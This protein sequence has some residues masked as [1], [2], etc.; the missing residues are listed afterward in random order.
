MQDL[1]DKPRLGVSSCLLG[2][3]IRYDGGHCRNK[4]VC[5]QLGLFFQ[6]VPICPEVEMGMPVPRETVRLVAQD[7]RTRL[8]GN[9]SGTDYSEAMR[10]Y[11]ERK[12]KQIAPLRLHGYILKKNSP[13]CGMERVPLYGTAGGRIGKTGGLFAAAMTR[14]FPLLPVEEEGRLNDLALKDNFVERVYAYRRWQRFA[15]SIHAP[16]HL[17]RFHT[18]H[19]YQLMAHDPKTYRALGRL[20]AQAGVME[21]SELLPRY[22]TQFM[23]CLKIPADAKR[24]ANV[25]Y[26]VMGFLKDSLDREDKHELLGLIERYRH[27]ELS[28]TAPLTLIEHHLRKHP[29][30]W[31]QQQHYLM[32]YPEA[33][34]M[35]HRL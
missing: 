9:K 8:V 5:E 3:S 34:T 13:T 16:R 21:M 18:R 33:F 23:E 24:Q 35:R 2:N 10:A 27:R 1:D 11:T 15:A 20:V 29:N 28:L 6:W 4:M 22:G 19:K 32:P 30:P 25:L 31:V 14:A 7:G 12:L 17:V 26:H